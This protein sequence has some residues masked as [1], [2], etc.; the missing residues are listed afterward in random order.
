MK[1]LWQLIKNILLFPWRLL[2]WL[3]QIL[4]NLLLLTLILLLV[5]V[6]WGRE[7]QVAAPG[8]GALVIAPSGIL[9]EQ[10][11]YTD[12][13]ALLLMDDDRREMETSLHDVT[14][15]IRRAT[16]DPDVTALVIDAG[17]L[18]GADP[19]KLFSIGEA[20]TQF[21][22]SKKP[23]FAMGDHYT[24]AQ[25]FLASYADEIYLNPMG[26]VFLNGLGVYPGYF[27][28]ALDKL[29]VTVHIFRVG[30][31]KSFVEP[32]VRNDMSEESRRNTALWLN[33]VW[34]L[35][36][37]EIERQRK[38]EAGAVNHYINQLD[39]RLA[40]TQGDAAQ[41]ALQAGLVDR[42]ATRDEMKK[43]LMEKIGS[44]KA[45]DSFPSVAF[46]PYVR[47][48]HKK[49]GLGR[50]VG[51]V[52][53]SGTILDGEH[54]AGNI[55]GDS[56]A[57]QI[58][59][60]REEGNVQ[61]LVLRIDSPGGSAFAAEIIRREIQLTQEAGIPVVASFGG[62]AASG[63][64][65]IAAGADE[66]WSTPSTITGSIGVFGLIP[67]FDESF[68]ALGIHSDGVGT[69]ALAD[70]WHLDRPMNPILERSIQLEVEHTYQRFITLAAEGRGVTP[71]KIHAVAQGQVWSGLQARKLGL[72]DHL[73]D[74]SGAIAAAAKLAEMG[75]EYEWEII[76]PKLSPQEQF[77]R[78]LTSEASRVLAWTGLKSSRSSSV[79]DR[80][81]ASLQEKLAQLASFNDPRGVYARCMECV[82]Q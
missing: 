82:V 52:V 34:T 45:G 67:V 72:V 12:P 71:E 30:D 33:D 17:R 74:L 61:A 66:I 1:T 50:K 76:E 11:S 68:K 79:V 55:G 39:Q 40:A 9:V 32:F 21:K 80:F 5:A 18:R 29:K 16:T 48:L 27:K 56:L 69:T 31:Y 70:A 62:V 4:A 41:A 54:P 77:I 26:G 6:F 75:D 22:T 28:E 25:Y 65:W 46:K 81:L 49:T 8:K 59:Q 2:T 3:R 47:S 51:V 10:R 36:S 38:M 53:A 14:L 42:L 64:Y 60:I 63:G 15:A 44:N 58:Q 57:A 7:K 78:Q 20:I 73:G 13:M 35:V 37:T 43:F 23:V 19:S 24:Q